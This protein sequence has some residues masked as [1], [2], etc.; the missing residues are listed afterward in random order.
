MLFSAIRT[1]LN[2]GLYIPPFIADKV[3][4]VTERKG[5]RPERRND[6]PLTPRQ[7]EILSLLSEGTPNKVIAAKLH[8]SEKTIKAHITVIFK[9]LNVV[10]RTQA[11]V[12][13]RQAGLI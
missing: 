8:L 9:A 4:E 12:V 6:R 1:V 7:I 5:G 3:P 10:N 13:A 2:G 11:S